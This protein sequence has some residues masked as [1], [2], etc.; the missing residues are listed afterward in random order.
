LSAEISYDKQRDYW[1]N[2]LIVATVARMI[3]ECRGVPSGLH[4]LADAVDALAFMAE[5]QRASDG[6]TEPLEA[7]DADRGWW[8]TAG[9]DHGATV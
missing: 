4:F 3:S 7:S 9:D 2:G 1:I 5:L 8:G 6:L